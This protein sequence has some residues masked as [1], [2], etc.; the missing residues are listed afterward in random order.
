MFQHFGLKR[1]GL[2]RFCSFPEAEENPHRVTSPLA[3]PA[4]ETT[5]GNHTE[6]SDQATLQ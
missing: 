1:Y 2:S 4:S 5:D 3:N 6:C